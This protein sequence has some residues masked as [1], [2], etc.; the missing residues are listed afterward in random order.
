MLE[1]VT[2]AVARLLAERAVANRRW[3]QLPLLSQKPR[4]I[5]V[6]NDIW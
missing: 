4:M 2:H 3:F 1:A 5:D 6:V